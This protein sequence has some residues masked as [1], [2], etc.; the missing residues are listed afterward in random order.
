MI[1]DYGYVEV[2]NPTDDPFVVRF[3][4][5]EAAVQVHGYSHGFS[6]DVQF[7]SQSANWL[8][9]GQNY[10]KE[11]RPELWQQVF[12]TRGQLRM[13]SRWATVLP[14]AFPTLLGGD[15][16]LLPA[17]QSAN[18]RSIA[19]QRAAEENPLPRKLP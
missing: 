3:E 15:M 2:E 4:K 12:K 19:E 6:V 1:D 14:E 5:R 8:V 17:L 13:A 9:S 11:N 18:R 10:L 16:S 7:G